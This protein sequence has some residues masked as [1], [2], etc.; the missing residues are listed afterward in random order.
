MRVTVYG[1]GGYN[2]DLPNGNVVDEYEVP[3]PPEPPQSEQ[4]DVQAL[5]EA[6]AALSPATLDALKAALGLT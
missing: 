5:A 3:A 6:L 2:P 4:S 1:E